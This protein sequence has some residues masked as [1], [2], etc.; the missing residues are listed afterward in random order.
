M[1][2]CA[3]YSAQIFAER[4]GAVM[5]DATSRLLAWRELMGQRRAV[6]EVVGPMMRFLDSHSRPVPAYLLSH[7]G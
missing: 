7:L 2:A 5:T 1:L 4:K 6:R 3:L